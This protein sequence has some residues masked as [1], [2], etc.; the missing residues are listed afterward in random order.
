ML[1]RVVARRL[2]AWSEEFFC[3]QQNGIRRAWGI[4]DCS[5]WTRKVA[6]YASP[7]PPPPQRPGWTTPTG[8]KEI[9][10]DAAVGPTTS[11]YREPI[12]C[13]FVPPPRP[14]TRSGH[15]RHLQASPSKQAT[16]C[17]LS[18]YPLCSCD[19]R[20]AGTSPCSIVCRSVSYTPRSQGV[21]CGSRQALPGS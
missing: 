19:A 11:L 12:T 10:G 9:R 1:A 3:E 21:Q 13:S 2:P 8:L 5:N 4:N 17:S 6:V 20:A 18:A 16:T 14:Q 15:F 7:P